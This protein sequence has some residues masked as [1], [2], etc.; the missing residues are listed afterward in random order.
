MPHRN[1][2]LPAIGLLLASV[3]ACGSGHGGSEP[4]DGVPPTPRGSRLLGIAISDRADGD[5]NAAFAEA[6]GAGM[7]AT[8]LSLGWNDL[9][10]APGVYDPAIDYLALA[11]G[12]YPSRGVRLLLSINPIDTNRTRLPTHLEGRAWND[13]VVVDAFKQLLDWALARAA[14]LDLVALSIGNEIDAA[15][16][17]TSEWESY[18]DFH[19][20]VAAHARSIRPGIRVGAKVTVGGILGPFADEARALAEASGLVLATHYPLGPGFQLE[21]PSSVQDVFDEVVA[22]SGELPIIFAEIGAPSTASCGSSEAVQAEF[23]ERAFQAW[24]RHAGRIEL[25][26]FVWMHDVDQAALDRYEQYYGVSDPC[27]LDY[28]A[29]LGLQAADGTDKPAWVRLV[30]EAAARGW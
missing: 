24:D 29:T 23:V 26:E 7:Q 8:S 1:A 4:G 5:F 21:P 16:G 14:P 3:A 27:F 2:L 20:Q 18:R 28:L 19:L 12:Y 9:E 10:V 17:S 15:L 6:V 25:L 30:Q 13:P 11:A 22:R